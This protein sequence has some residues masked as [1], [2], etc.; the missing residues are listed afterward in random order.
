MK[1]QTVLILII[2]CFTATKAQYKTMFPSDSITWIQ[3]HEIID[4]SFNETY[5]YTGKKEMI[6]GEIWHLIKINYLSRDS[7]YIKE[8]TISGKTWL[9]KINSFDNDTTEFVYMDLNLNLEDSILYRYDCRY[10]SS[11]IQVAKI[12]T[13]HNRKVIEFKSPRNYLTRNLS[14]KYIEGIGSNFGFTNAS[15]YC[16]QVLCKL[17][18]E[19][20]LVYALD[21]INLSC[22]IVSDIDTYDLSESLSIYPNPVQSMLHISLKKGSSFP[23]AIY[24]YDLYGRQLFHQNL[25]EPQTSLDLSHLTTQIIFYKLLFDDYTVNG[26]I[27]KQ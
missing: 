13:I 25:V 20:K 6:N 16:S 21:T 10:D 12:D 3:T 11:Y 24:F 22:P 7:F 4:G 5:N 9:L 26:K 1:I 18:Y 8:D 17:Y 27:L 23:Y 15:G 19:D 14:L 2:F